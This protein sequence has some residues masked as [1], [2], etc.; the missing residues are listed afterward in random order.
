MGGAGPIFAFQGARV[1]AEA[2]R[3]AGKAQQAINDQNAELA[4]R[5]ALE[6]ENRTL[7][8]SRL[9]REKQRRIESSNIAG[10][11][12]SGVNLEGSPFLLLEEN[13]A[14]AEEE[15]FLILREG[16][17]QR[18]KLIAQSNLDTFKG[19]VARKAGSAKGKAILLAGKAKLVSDITDL[20]VKAATAGAT[21]GQGT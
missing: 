5:A 19:K 21:G 13:A 3:N 7:I 6:Q 18:N 15:N 9:E 8:E 12:A 4:K 2:A 16:R 14:R 1:Q 11:G 20:S 10:T 17:I